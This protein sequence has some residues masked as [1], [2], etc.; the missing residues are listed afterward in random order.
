MYHHP[1]EDL[2]LFIRQKATF[3]EVFCGRELIRLPEVLWKFCEHIGGAL[4]HSELHFPCL[5]VI[6]VHSQT[7]VYWS[8][9]DAQ[10][11]AYHTDSLDDAGNDIQGLV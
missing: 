11:S 5:G 8:L 9:R 7:F 3:E 1:V 6:E 2:G 10:L 4:L